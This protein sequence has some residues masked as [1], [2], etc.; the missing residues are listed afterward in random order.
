M[1]Q[2]EI[3][4]KIEIPTKPQ[5]VVQVDFSKNNEKTEEQKNTVPPSKASSVT[6]RRS[7]LFPKLSELD[8][9]APWVL[10]LLAIL[11]ILLLSML[12]L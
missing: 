7:T 2:D 3:T 5:T 4:T 8:L 12:V 11:A 6:L 9:T 10:R 1:H